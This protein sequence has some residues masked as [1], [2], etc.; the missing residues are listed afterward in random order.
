MPRKDGA[1][2]LPTSFGYWVRRRR[3]ALDLTQADLARKVGCAEVTIQKIEADER[4]PSTQ[5]AARL[6]E[7]LRISPDER[8][9]FL[10]SARGELAVDRLHAPDT[11][12][13]IPQHNL[14]L[15]LT[16]FIGRARE[17][18]TIAAMLGNARLLTL[19]GPGGSGKTRLALRLAE[20]MLVQFPSGIWLVEL[21]PLAD[22]A[23]IVQTIAT[24]LGVCEE[25]GRALL[26]TLTAYL[27]DKQLLLVLD[28]CEHLID[29][30]AQLADTLLRAA[31][32]LR[33]LASSREPLGIAGE[34]FFRVPAL[35]VPDPHQLP[36]LDQLA[37]YE[38]VQLFV[39][40]AG[41]VQP[42][43]EL[44]ATTAAPLAQ[45]CARLDGIPLAIELAAARLDDR[46]Q[47]LT[48]GS[49]TT[50]P[51]HQTLQALIDWSYDLLTD[52]ERVLLHRLAVFV[53]GWT[54]EAAEAVCD[55]S[56]ENEELRKAEDDRVVLS[57][58]FST[59]DLL[60]HLVDKS[61][62]QVDQA[63]NAARYRMLETIREYALERLEE[64]EEAEMLRHQHAAYYLALAEAA[65]A[66][67]RQ[68][69]Q[70]AWL[71][72]LAQE[73]NNLRAVLAWSRTTVAG[74]AIGLRL[75]AI[76]WRFWLSRGHLT[77]GRIWLAE[78][79]ARTGDPTAGS[80]VRAQ[81]LFGAGRLAQ[82]QNDYAAARGAFTESLAIARERGDTWSM[83]Q[84]RFELGNIAYY[85][86]DYVVARSQLM[87]S[88]AAWRALR[89]L[90]G[91][92]EALLFLG[93]LAWLQGDY[94]AARS[95]HE[96]SLALYRELG[97]EIYI[98][99]NL[100]SLGKIA[101]AEGEYDQ[102]R[103]L[104]EAGLAVMRQ[105][106]FW[107]GTLWALHHLGE[108]ARHQGDYGR[109]AALYE[110]SL[111]IAREIGYTS[112]SASMLN[113]LGEIAQVQGDYKRAGALHR[114]SL[115]VFRDLGHKRDILLC[116]EG[117]A[118]VAEGQAQA[119]R[120][121]RLYGAVAALREATGAQLPPRD[122]AN[123][124]RSMERVR[125]QL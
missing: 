100:M 34:A 124:A 59:L 31:S 26:A 35:A 38:A 105:W 51:R 50:L 69:V 91:S 112:G 116:L 14:P 4:R 39:A 70:G 28:N 71:E 55:L 96:E 76:L 83:T 45:I 89:N 30:C 101:G 122:R 23:L 60:G 2:N 6:A 94:A 37:H 12:A 1:M 41:A 44:T 64:S 57:A 7:Q 99:Y 13:T 21:A 107:G 84:A 24:V 67:L 125:A 81:A 102:A 18:V 111:A 22:P 73:H 86:G 88:L 27:H 58:Q 109:A 62:V 53:G 104:I 87:E 8:A 19:T 85:Q 113:R 75:A 49:R 95:F 46:F 15:Q 119:E 117:L 47:L 79:L 110:E 65:E 77:E 97:D 33:V 120:A 78:V 66:Q 98:A 54:L 52:Q 106:G 5:I 82:W 43:F 68:A 10:R 92:A 93:L 123:Y 61:L 25:P 40:R 72:R 16:S 9:A 108:L 90:A 48:G 20:D 56:I 121:A 63:G 3:K 32:R 17:L 118:L 42:A 115:T 29:A 114:E 103:T 80:G 74:A 11:P 36:P